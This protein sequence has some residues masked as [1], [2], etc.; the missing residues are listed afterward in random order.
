MKAKTIRLDLTP[1]EALALWKALRDA[2]L[3]S[4]DADYGVIKAAV[5]KVREAARDGFKA[6]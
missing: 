5:D 4:T 2:C 3:Y 1:G 6:P